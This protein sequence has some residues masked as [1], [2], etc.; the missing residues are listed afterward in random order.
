MSSKR[1]KT[2]ADASPQGNTCPFYNVLPEG[3]LEEVAKFLAPTSRILFAAA[4]TPTPRSPYGIILARNRPNVG[5][6]LIASNDWH[7]LDFGD[8]EKELAAKLS[9]DDISEALLHI[10]AANKVKR[11]RLT[12]CT[13]ITGACLS[14][15]LGCTSIEQIDLSLVG[16]HQP[17]QEDYLMHHLSCDLVLPI[18][19]SIISQERCSLKHLRFPDDWRYEDDPDD[20]RFLEFLVRYNA[21][22]ENNLT[23]CC[24]TRLDH[25]IISFDDCELGLGFKIGRA[26]NVPSI[27]A[28]NALMG[29]IIRCYASA[30]RVSESIVQHAWRWLSAFIATLFCVLTAHLTLIVRTPPAPI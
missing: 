25:G 11:L 26:T 10:D 21:M 14:P 22:L 15:L 20:P 27:T 2:A 1:R 29:M 12:N 23:A 6:S 24:G 9:D 5:H 3:I 17:T 28:A 19:D 7:T 13:S 16:A 18:L 4:V 30:T 8:I